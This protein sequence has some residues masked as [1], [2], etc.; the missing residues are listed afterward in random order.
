[1]TPKII[2]LKQA[3]V[4][5]VE[6]SKGADYK[7]YGDE[8]VIG[9]HVLSRKQHKG[10]GILSAL[11]EDQFAEC[12]ERIDQE[13]TFGYRDYTGFISDL[14]KARHSFSSLLRSE[15]V[16]T[17]NPYGEEQRSYSELMDGVCRDELAEDMRLWH[18]A[19]QRT[20]DLKRTVVLLRKGGCDEHV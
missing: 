17:E 15:N 20:I 8:V 19:Q 12:V 2:E 13:H 11:T 1:M 7:V 9:D 10:L 18:E 6:L 5:L 3:P 4:V 16:Y 14:S